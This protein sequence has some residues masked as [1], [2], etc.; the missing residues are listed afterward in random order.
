MISNV[1]FNLLLQ[2]LLVVSTTAQA[3]ERFSVKDWNESFARAVQKNDRVQIEKLT[4]IQQIEDQA[5]GLCVDC[6]NKNQMRKARNLFAKGEYAEAEKIYNTIPK[7]TDLWLEA[8]E[9]RGWTHFRRDNF[10]KALAQTKTLLS[11]QFVAAVNSEAFFLQSLAQLKICNYEGILETH[12]AFKEKQRSRILAI[13]ELSKVGVNDALKKAIAE[14]DKFPLSYEDLGEVLTN[15]P[16]LFYRDLEIQKQFLRL[17]VAQSGLTV[18]SSYN[19]TFSKMKIESSEKLKKRLQVLANQENREN[20]KI[21]QK[22][23]LIEVEAIQRI[24]TD[25]KLSQENYTPGK[26]KKTNEDQLIFMDDGQPWIDELDKYDV[27]AKACNKNIR[28]KM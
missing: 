2:A 24:H 8:V 17:K 19:K 28:R 4:N 22:L 25:L 7:G 10:E 20:S 15:L 12:K 6:K 16:L 3:A 21:I 1:G 27:A 26:F 5:I 13:Q 14:M 11:P 23:N 18:N 9:E